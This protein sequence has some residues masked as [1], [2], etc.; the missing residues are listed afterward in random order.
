LWRS[1][2]KPV[3]TPANDARRGT[4]SLDGSA[5]RA[6][7]AASLPSAHSPRAR[8]SCH[9]SAGRPFRVGDGSDP[10]FDGPEPDQLSPTTVRILLHEGISAASRLVASS[11]RRTPPPLRQHDVSDHLAMILDATPR[12]HAVPSARR[13]SF[14]VP[15]R[16]HVPCSSFDDHA[17]A[18]LTSTIHGALSFDGPIH[19][20][21]SCSLC[22]RVLAYPRTS[23]A[24]LRMRARGRLATTP[25]TPATSE[26]AARGRRS[27][28]CSRVFQRSSAYAAQRCSVR[29]HL[30]TPTSEPAARCAPSGR[31]PRCLAFPL[32]DRR[33]Q[34]PLGSFEPNIRPARRLS[35]PPGVHRCLSTPD[36]TAAPCTGFRRHSALDRLRADLAISRSSSSSDRADR[37][38]SHDAGDPPAL[39]CSRSR[40]FSGASLERSCDRSTV[41]RSSTHVSG[42][43]LSIPEHTHCARSY[44]AYCH[45]E[46]SALPSRSEP[47]CS[48]FRAFRPDLRVHEIAFVFA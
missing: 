28:G 17:R 2:R 8:E 16:H 10:S 3:S 24:R 9:V 14:D 45:R 4:S 36:P 48:S 37:F 40:M 26:E 15:P 39:P 1:D 44:S 18:R 23:E 43:D 38:A 33:R 12:N 19:D 5:S 22:T 27:A 31:T 25:R 47:S 20:R 7:P 30:P 35:P 32:R 6:H 21:G 29:A 42:S 46:S 11:F 13:Q 34:V 41:L